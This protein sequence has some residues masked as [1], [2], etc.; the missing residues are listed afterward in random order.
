MEHK[1]KQCHRELNTEPE[2]CNLFTKK[3]NLSQQS[4]QQPPNLQDSPSVAPTSRADIGSDRH[5]SQQSDRKRNGGGRKGK[6]EQCAFV[7]TKI[8]R[9]R[10]FEL[11]CSTISTSASP[12]APAERPRHAHTGLSVHLA[13]E[14]EKRSQN[15]TLTP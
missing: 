1:N 9:H 12:A 2:K 8:S 4:V 6:K 14:E 5:D 3:A 7:K 13:S 15:K 10:A 11:I